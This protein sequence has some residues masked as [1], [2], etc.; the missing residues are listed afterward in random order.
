MTIGKDREWLSDQTKVPMNKNRLARSLGNL[1]SDITG[2]NERKETD[3]ALAEKSKVEISSEE[4]DEPLWN[5]NEK[6]VL[7]S[8]DSEGVFHLDIETKDNHALSEHQWMYR[9]PYGTKHGPFSSANMQEWFEAGYFDH[10]LMIKRTNDEQYKPL[11]A[12]MQH[13]GAFSFSGETSMLKNSFLH[14]PVCQPAENHQACGRMWGFPQQMFPR[15]Q[16]MYDESYHQSIVNQQ[17]GQHYYYL[18]H[19]AQQHHQQQYHLQSHQ[20]VIQQHQRQQYLHELQQSMMQPTGNLYPDQ[21]PQIQNEQEQPHMNETLVD[22]LERI[23]ISNELI[24]HSKENQIFTEQSEIEKSVKDKGSEEHLP[25][26]NSEKQMSPVLNQLTGIASVE[27]PNV[28]KTSVSVTDKACPSKEFLNWCRSSLRGL[29]KGVESE[30]IL[31]MILEF[32]VCDDSYL[33]IIQDIVY[34][35]S[36]SMDGRRFAR[37]FITHR[38]ADQRGE[39]NMHVPTPAASED[40]KVVSSKKSLKRNQN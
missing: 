38:I 19:Q 31:G 10:S 9:G 32:P 7:G 28:E 11:S 27:Y 2:Y 21:V 14:P 22:Q 39:F 25:N 3:I 24:E 13:N 18:L 37:D 17:V 16:D 29:N 15:Q 1:E 5:V 23:T 20:N 12:F 33:D 6:D 35:N 34:V 30:A 36:T 8:F 26:K 4:E 40:F